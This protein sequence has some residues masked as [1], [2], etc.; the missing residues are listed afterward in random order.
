MA[1]TYHINLRTTLYIMAIW[2]TEGNE[3]FR[4]IMGRSFIMQEGLMDL[5]DAGAVV[6]RLADVIEV[7][8]GG[9]VDMSLTM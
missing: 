4:F 1:D 2:H 5:E 3:V 7:R 8:K 6:E 9:R